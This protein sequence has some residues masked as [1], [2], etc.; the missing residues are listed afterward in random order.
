MMVKITEDEKEKG[1]PSSVNQKAKCLIIKDK[2]IE[3]GLN[4]NRDSFQA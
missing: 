1:I 2:T 4:N 3:W